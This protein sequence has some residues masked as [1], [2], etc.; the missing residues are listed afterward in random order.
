MI[1]T[2]DDKVFF[3][4]SKL[5]REVLYKLRDKPQVASFIAKDLGKHRESISRILLDLKDREIAECKNPES[6]NFRYYQITSKG[7]KVLNKIN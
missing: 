1:I 5:R 2:D 7:K 6:S 3:A 4:R